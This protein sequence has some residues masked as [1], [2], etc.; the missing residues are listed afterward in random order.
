MWKRLKVAD[1]K[2]LDDGQ[3]KGVHIACGD[4]QSGSCVT[5]IFDKSV[6]H[7]ETDDLVHLLQ[8]KLKL[9]EVIVETPD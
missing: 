6:P 3:N 9:S 4:D 7:Q 5:L 2:C 8:R 1:V